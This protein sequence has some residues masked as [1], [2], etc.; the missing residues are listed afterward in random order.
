MKI[1]K[2]KSLIIFFLILTIFNRIYPSIDNQEENIEI[3]TWVSHEVTPEIAESLANMGFSDVAIRYNTPEELNRTKQVLNAFNL[4]Y[5]Q[6]IN[7]WL[8]YARGINNTVPFLEQGKSITEQSL[9]D[10]CHALIPGLYGGKEPEEWIAMLDGLRGDPE[11][12]LTFYADNSSLNMFRTYNFSGINVDLYNTPDG[13]SQEYIL[14]VKELVGSLG[15]YLWVW[16]GHGW[17]WESITDEE[18]VNV[19]SLAEQT[20]VDR[21]CVWL[22]SESEEEEEGMALSSFLNYPERWNLL[23]ECNSKLISDEN[24]SPLPSVTPSISPTSTPLPSNTPSPTPV[25]TPTA[26]PSPTPEP[27]PTP[28]LTPT[29]TVAPTS[30]PIPTETPEPTASTTLP[31]EPINSPFAEK[32]LWLVVASGLLFIAFISIIKIKNKKTSC[33]KF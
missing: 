4:S 14:E 7:A 1:Y 25:L 10:D 19:Y 13:Y 29:Q 22:A 33:N 26:S 27:T 28:T 2:I 9:V 16:A 23:S 20:M 24:I 21:F 15:L 17:T 12:I 31:S 11:V 6:H 18:I 32:Y 8:G 30:S 5:W 3:F